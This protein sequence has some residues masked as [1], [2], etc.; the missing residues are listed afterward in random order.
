MKSLADRIEA[1]VLVIPP[2][3]CHYWQGAVANKN[4]LRPQPVIK[5][6]GK[7]RPLRRVVYEM[8]IGE[9]DEEQHEK[10]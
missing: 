8:A 3:S 1:Q 5:L 4:A 7:A 9:I 10:A 6:A 2:S